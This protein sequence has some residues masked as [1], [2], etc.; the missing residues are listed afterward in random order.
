MNETLAI[1]VD[2]LHR[3]FSR[4]DTDPQFSTSAEVLILPAVDRGRHVGWY[5]F[6]LAAATY[7]TAARIPA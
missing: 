6:R 5:G 3:D 4:T 2:T 1:V 7:T